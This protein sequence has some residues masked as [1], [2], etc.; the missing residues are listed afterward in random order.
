MLNLSVLA[1][2]PRAL[3]VYLDY[4]LSKKEALRTPLTIRLTF[5]LASFNS[6]EFMEFVRAGSCLVFR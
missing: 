5:V 1:A 6:G 4:L 3:F 2:C